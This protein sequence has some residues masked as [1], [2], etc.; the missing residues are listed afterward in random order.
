[1]FA[2]GKIEQRLGHQKE[3][4]DWLLRAR[5]LEPRNTS[6][7]KEICA[8]AS[9][10]EMHGIAARIADDAIEHNNDDPA[11]RINSGLA[12]ILAG[13]CEVALER[14]KEAVRMEP[15]QLNEKLQAYAVRV[16]TGMLPRPTTETDIMKMLR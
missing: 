8:T 4:L 16:L 12:H 11:L 7:A 14:F 15:T 5:E 9:G 13:N 10:L 1:M 3:A 6:I 2:I